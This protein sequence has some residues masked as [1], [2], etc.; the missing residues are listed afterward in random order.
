MKGLRAFLC[1]GMIM[2]HMK[3]TSKEFCP[4]LKNRLIF[5][6]PPH[7][8][9]KSVPLVDLSSNM[10]RFFRKLWD[11]KVGKIRRV[12][13]GFYGDSNH[14]MDWATS[15]LRE[16][17]GREFGYGGHGFIAAAQPW[18]WYQHR[19]ISVKASRGWKSYAVSIPKHPSKSYGHSGILGIGFSGSSIS[20]KSED[21]GSLENR[22]FDQ[23]EVHYNCQ[24]TKGTLNVLIDKKVVGTINTFCKTKSYKIARFQTNL[25][26]H[27]VELRVTQGAPFV[28]GLS[29]ERNQSGLVVD[30]LG[31][32][33]LNLAMMARLDRNIF[34]SGL[35]A[36]N[37]DL[38]II[39]T[40]TNMWAPRGHPRW[41]KTVIDR[42]R[43]ALGQDV[44]I[45]L[46]SPPDFRDKKTKQPH[47]R[48][49]QCGKEKKQIA[50]NEKVAF[51]DYYKV[52]GGFG[53]ILKWRKQGLT[54]PDYVH[55]KEGL[56]KIM[57]QNFA[58]TLYQHGKSLWRKEFPLCKI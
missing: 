4:S 15:V 10:K 29:F 27:Q 34:H 17:L 22:V 7:S 6:A 39:H 21:R 47:I 56:H 24:P 48:M 46:L 2:C 26:K 19:E 35:T 51:W 43:L 54:A 52:M 30:G 36:R 53:S 50:Q 8:G 9:L 38:V 1:L 58:E 57:M 25:G 41:A 49:A 32:G 14:T 5:S 55:L 31:V 33:A 28:Y 44:S 18:G 12:R 20:Y 45:L 42:L 16:H 11:L 23:I 3:A 37:Y 40:G 13:I